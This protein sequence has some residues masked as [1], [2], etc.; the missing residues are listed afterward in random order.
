M[1]TIERLD[2]LIG[3]EHA[4]ALV[5]RLSVGDSKSHAV[6]FYG[7]DGAGK[8]QLAGILAQAWLCKAPT[9]EGACGICG[10][11]QA[12]IRGNHPDL[13]IIEPLPPSHIIRLAAVTGGG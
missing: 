13:L 8:T 3:L 12:S 4:K 9:S 2:G 11:C 6:L 1:T 5:R 7:P 10:S